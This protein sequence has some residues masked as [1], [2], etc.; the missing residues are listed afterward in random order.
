MSDAVGMRIVDMLQQITSGPMSTVWEQAVIMQYVYSGVCL[1]LGLG[2]G[3][4]VL[5]L[6]SWWVVTEETEDV[7]RA[8][9]WFFRI[10]AVVSAALLIA[11]AVCGLMAPELYAL[12][13]LVG[14]LQ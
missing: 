5:R 4:V 12:N 11:R 2:F 3:F 1:V 13:A 8:G 14:G 6:P 9:F 10:S 7:D